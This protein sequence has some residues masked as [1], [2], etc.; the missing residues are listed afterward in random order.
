[1]KKSKSFWLTSLTLLL[2][3][4]ILS[5]CGGKSSTPPSTLVE[6]IEVPEKDVAEIETV[7]D[8]ENKSEIVKLYSDSFENDYG[9]VIS[10]EYFLSDGKRDVLCDYK[11]SVSKDKDPLYNEMMIYYS[12]TMFVSEAKSKKV[13]AALTSG[14]TDGSRAGAVIMFDAT[15]NSW[16]I[17]GGYNRSGALVSQKELD[18]FIEL[19]NVRHDE[20][21]DTEWRDRMQWADSTMS[22]CFDKIR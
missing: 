21:I 10:F 7:D 12:M 22:S 9:D 17:A 18:W 14:M 5:S 1:M 8:N 16:S 20:V 19:D 15:K 4:S 11:P 3:A 6:K 13:D 2:C